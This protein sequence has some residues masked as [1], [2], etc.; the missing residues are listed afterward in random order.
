VFCVETR[1][2]ISHAARSAPKD[3]PSFSKEALEALKEETTRFNST[4]D[5]FILVDEDQ[6]RWSMPELQAIPFL[7][8][9]G[10]YWGPPS[11]DYVAIDACERLRKRGA[12]YVAFVWPALWWLRHYRAI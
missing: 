12:Q 6:V 7:E 2:M 4:E 3:S 11:D 10:T 1:E 9:T 5:P 8:K